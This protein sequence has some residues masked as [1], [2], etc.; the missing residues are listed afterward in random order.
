MS[1]INN[2]VINGFSI[3]ILVILF[4]HSLKRIEEKSFQQR[5]YVKMVLIT[6]LLLMLD[7]LSRTDGYLG[8]IFPVINH[9]SNFLL[10][11]LNPVLPSLWF[12]YA[13]FQVYHDEEKTKRLIIPLLLLNAV[14]V[15]M[16]IVT[17]FNGWYYFID[18][19]NIYHRGPF[20][21]ISTLI[22]FVLLIAAFAVGVRNRKTI[23]SKQL[24]ALVF[25]P[26]PP[27]VG[28]ILQIFI[29]G[30]SF[31]MNS[32]VLSLLIVILNMKDDSI[33][34]DYLTG[35]GN[36]KKFESI[37]KESVRKSSK[38]KTFSLVMLD[39]DEFKEIN[40]TFGHEMGDKALQVS[41]DL[42]E[43]C[44]RS[45]DYV[46]RYGGDEF[47]LLLDINDIVTLEATVRRIKDTVDALNNSGEF[48][49]RLKF[50]VGYAVYDYQT[51]M[52]AEDFVKHVDLL[53]Y[54]NKRLKNVIAD[55][56]KLPY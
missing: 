26:V 18:A 7:I 46:A 48:P 35:I 11:L 53:M 50:T 22:I 37:L 21:V 31:V 39:L 14:N 51:D 10:F 30:I 55:Q 45:K 16:V 13:D 47:C 1:L 34:T 52:K 38:N 8:T 6:I 3:L 4:L 56:C 41:A 42:L 12:M 23:D 5:M 28:V 49:F 29:Y 32:I 9:V 43:K 54:E 20:F 17:Q 40:D 33:F 24:L 15:V 44:I 2:I 27:I 36:R 19:N 25:F